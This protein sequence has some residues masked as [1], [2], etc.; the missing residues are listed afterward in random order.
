MKN[1]C[2]NCGRVH[3]YPAE[4]DAC[5]DRVRDRSARRWALSIIGACIALVVA[6]Q[7]A[8]SV[9]AYGDW[10]CAFAECRKV[11]VVP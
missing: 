2:E 1:P 10:T 8:W 11:K 3:V 7:I 9:Y 5:D 4:R 6:I